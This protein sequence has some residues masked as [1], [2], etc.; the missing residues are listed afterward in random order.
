VTT[1]SEFED[2]HGEVQNLLAAI[3]WRVDA[4][5]DTTPDQIKNEIVECSTKLRECGFNML[6]AID[7]AVDAYKQAGP[8]PPL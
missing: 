6:K 3:K 4:I 1:Q 2:L 5:N 8:F 7:R